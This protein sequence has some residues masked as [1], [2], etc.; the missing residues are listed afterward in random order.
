MQANKKDSSMSIG[1]KCVVGFLS[2]IFIR[3]AIFMVFMV[4]IYLVVAFSPDEPDHYMTTDLAEYGI[5]S[6]NE[7]NKTPQKQMDAFFPGQLE[8]Y[9]EDIA[10]TYS[11]KNVDSYGFEAYLEFTIRDSEQFAAYLNDTLPQTDA[12][13]FPFG[14]GFQVY[15]LENALEL[16][17]VPETRQPQ[18]S[19]EKAHAAPL[20]Q[21]V[22]DR[23]WISIGYAKVSL[24]LVSR[25]EQR[26]I[27]S[28]MGVGNEGVAGTTELDRLLTRFDIDPLALAA[29]LRSDH[30]VQAEV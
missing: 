24:I 8:P 9:F 29:F 21:P 6:G 30:T 26:V 4:L 5:C 17:T 3:K 2:W 28:A 13:E 14:E 16:G 18:I 7:D 11:A 19:A 10:Y 1:L 15:I 12:V 25:E 23:P 20:V 27:Y 22:E